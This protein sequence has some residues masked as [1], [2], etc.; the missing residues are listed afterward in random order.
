MQ[1]GALSSA[2][3]IV[4]R[5]SARARI[6][7]SSVRP[8]D[9]LGVA[10]SVVYRMVR[11]DWDEVATVADAERAFRG[12]PREIE[13]APSAPEAVE[14]ATTIGAAAA[15]LRVMDASYMIGVRSGDGA[16]AIYRFMT[17][18][19]AEFRIATMARVLGVSPSGVLH[20]AQPRAL[21]RARSDEALSARV[22]EIHQ[23]IRGWG[24][25]GENMLRRSIS[26]SR[27]RCFSGRRA[28]RSCTM[29]SSARIRFN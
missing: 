16:G 29:R 22:R 9:R 12:L 1:Q 14:L 13:L 28:S 10:R 27:W 25:Q 4:E 5:G 6:L 8:I 24:R 11:S 15:K 19:Q 7:A 26:R 21:V 23:R 17:A 20:V 3:T 18:H 2:R